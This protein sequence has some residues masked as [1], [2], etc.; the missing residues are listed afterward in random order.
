MIT[1]ICPLFVNQ[2]TNDI[3][4]NGTILTNEGG[5]PAHRLS[6]MLCSGFLFAHASRRVCWP[7]RLV[8]T[9]PPMPLRL[10]GVAAISDGGAHA[11]RRNVPCGVIFVSSSPLLRFV[12]LLR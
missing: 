5:S 6:A 10:G 9:P 11:S 7:S 12:R 2:H 3:A 1:R 4:Q 8:A